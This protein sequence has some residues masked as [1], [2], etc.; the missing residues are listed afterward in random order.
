MS[1]P[2]HAAHSFDPRPA[3]PVLAAVVYTA[4]F[5]SCLLTISG[6]LG[7]LCR[8]ENWCEV[9]EVETILRER[10]VRCDFPL[11]VVVLTVLSC[12]LEI[13]GADIPV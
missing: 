1:D 8:I 9:S 3:D 13:L 7:S 11:T 10:E 2:E 12:S 4:L 5:K 6:L